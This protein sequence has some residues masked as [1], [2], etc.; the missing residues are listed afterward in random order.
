MSRWR[1]GDL[2][3]A[4]AAV[5]LGLGAAWVADRPWADG[6]F[7]A[8][9]VLALLVGLRQ[10]LRAVRTWRAERGAAAE[11]TRLR[12]P[13]VA[14]AAVLE[15]RARLAAEIETVVRAGL[16]RMCRAA[17]RAEEAWST[18]PAGRLREIQL[19]GRAVT[20]ELR[21]MLGLLRDEAPPSEEQTAPAVAVARVRRSDL[22]LAGVAVLVVVAETV[23]ARVLAWSETAGT[24]PASVTLTVL[25]AA[26][27]AGRTLAPGGSTLLLAALTVTGT[28]LG[29][30]VLEGLWLLVTA[31]TLA[32]ASVAREPRWVW[33]I[34]APAALVAGLVHKHAT[35]RPD[36][37]TIALI[38][39]AVG[40]L[41]GLVVR[42]LRARAEQAEESAAERRSQLSTFSATAVRQERL[43]IARELHDLV[44]G[45]VS[46][47]VMQ[48]GAAEV[49]LETDRAAAHRALGVVLDTCA[50]TL[51][52]L[53]HLAAA[54]GA[55]P[56]DGLT[57]LVDRLRAAGLPVELTVAGGLGPAGPTVHR[58]VQEALLNVLR[59]APGA[60]ARV[61][62]TARPGG[63]VVEVVDDGPGRAAGKPPGYGLVGLAERLEQAGGTLR[64]GPG[65]DGRGFL[66]RAELLAPGAS[67]Q[68]A[69]GGGSAAPSGAPEPHP[70]GGSA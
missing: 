51:A 70:A 3:L 26:T 15:E 19:E 69:R 34:A 17:E 66:L 22:V 14:Q 32:W 38:I 10:V 63:V 5:A 53:D 35:V 7:V 42:L 36:N 59:H 16:V 48:A 37:L 65:D 57:G 41:G 6:V 12:P 31:G 13:A 2:G 29:H 55:P 30:P 68:A 60:S 50:Q 18:G 67:A 28:L 52:D 9:L 54:A 58:V 61:S 49:Q 25:A 62:V 33:A 64:T 45:S 20:S 44:S 4:A 23:A 47:M 24:T 8:C 11:I 43:T 56:D 21:R 39:V 1:R 40:S 27:V 46:V